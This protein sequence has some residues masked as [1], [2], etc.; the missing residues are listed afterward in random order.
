MN[1]YKAFPSEAEI[2]TDP[3]CKDNIHEF[4][5]EIYEEGYVKGEK[6]TIEKAVEWL[7]ENADKYIVDI[8]VETY[9]DAPQNLIVGGM[10]W[11]HLKDYLNQD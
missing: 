7:K 3:I 5:R 2:V 10:C 6:N 11:V 9:P 1:A 8:A 4:C